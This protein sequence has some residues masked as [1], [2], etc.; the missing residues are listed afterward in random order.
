VERIPPA[1]AHE[2]PTGNSPSQSSSRAPVPG[3]IAN[4]APSRRPPQQTRQIN[5]DEGGFG[6]IPSASC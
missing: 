6:V 4:S 5:L 1:A 3:E 2:L